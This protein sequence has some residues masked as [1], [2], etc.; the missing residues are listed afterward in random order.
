MVG[1][2]S[3][4]GVAA[5]VRR[6]DRWHRLA[7][8]A[9]ALAAHAVV[10]IALLWILDEL[11]PRW[12]SPVSWVAVVWL[13]AFAVLHWRWSGVSV[14]VLDRRFG[15]HD[16]LRTWTGGVALGPMRDWLERDLG[17]RIAGLSPSRQ[18][19]PVRQ[20]LRP[21]RV[22][23][24]LLLAL[25]IL[26]SLAPDGDLNAG[27]GGGGG[28]AAGGA[29]GGTTS[30][31]DPPESPPDSPDTPPQDD[32]PPP[33][34]DDHPEDPPPDEPD[35]PGAPEDLIDERPN[36]DEFV[37]PHFVGDGPSRTEQ[38]HVADVGSGGTKPP[39][40]QRDPTGQPN[41]DPPPPEIAE[42]DRAAERALRSRHVREDERDT[43][44]RYFEL[45]RKRGR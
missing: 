29:A 17:A 36:Q 35:P 14:D 21:L 15:L 25:I 34:P 1:R 31:D 24:P 18:W 23:V 27:L 2:D 19:K 33:P 30:S 7:A 32:P 28:G 44:R 38:A 37:L 43:V 12:S 5:F 6:L 16:A 42:F 9:A 26:R 8:V 10:V 22:L 13:S 4:S 20:R 39:P 40:T 3:N 11:V 41:E 45:L